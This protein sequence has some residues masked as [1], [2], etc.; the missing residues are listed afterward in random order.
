MKSFV[1]SRHA[2]NVHNVR[3]H[4]FKREFAVHLFVRR[5]Y[6]AESRRRDV[7]KLFKVKS[8]RFNASVESCDSILEFRRHIDEWCQDGDRVMAI[9]TME[10]D[11]KANSFS[12]TLQ[13]FTRVEPK[14]AKTETEKKP[15]PQEDIF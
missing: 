6:L 3:L 10:K 8:E 4:I 9:G 12:F 13:E 5:D 7:F 2:E 14:E 15:E 1:K 11:A